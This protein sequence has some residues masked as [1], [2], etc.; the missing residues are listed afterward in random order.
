MDSLRQQ[1][2]DGKSTLGGW[3]SSDSTAVAESMALAGFDYVCVDMQHGVSDYTAATRQI[4][5]ILAADATP[6]VRVPWNDPGIIGKVLD[7][8]ALGV[9]VP[10]VNSVAEA[11]AVV[12]AC[13]YAPHG[14]RSFGPVLAAPRV[15]GNYME[16]AQENIAV[17]PMIETAKAVDDLDAILDVPGIDAVYV[18]PSDLSLTYG[19]PPVNNDG[20]PD[21]DNAL[22]KIISAC[23]ERGIVAGMHSNG[24]LIQPRLAAGFRML[25]VVSDLGAMSIGFKVEMGKAM[26]ASEPDDGSTSKT[27][28]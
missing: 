3:L 25:T 16:W 4:Q 20:E 22:A 17:I 21:F 11:E 1:W 2:R 18:G 6:I 5:A 13:R 9:I 19:L 7:A 10:M 28:Y 8:G 27:G 26:A 12:S 15:A 14:S 23:N 24:K